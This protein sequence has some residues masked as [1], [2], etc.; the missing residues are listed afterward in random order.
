MVQ[1]HEMHGSE[2]IQKELY[3]RRS[4]REH[5]PLRAHLRGGLTVL[6]VGCGPGT[7]TA[8]IAE[9]V[10]PGQV[11]GMDLEQGSLEKASAL[12]EERE[13]TNLSF[14][15][16]SIYEI[17]FA[18]GHFDVTYARHALEWLKDPLAGLK[19]MIRVTRKG[20]V[21]TA[22]DVDYG[23]FFIYPPVPALEEWARKLQYFGA[24][25]EID[26]HGRYY[27][28]RELFGLFTL[29]GLSDLKPRAVSRMT[30]R[31]A[32]DFDW[33]LKMVVSHLGLTGPYGHLNRRMIDE[34]ILLEETLVQ[35]RA[36]FRE[37]SAA[38]GAFSTYPSWIFVAGTAA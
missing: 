24:V 33:F 6:D 1:K 4:L 28:G 37:W 12:V 2:F 31:G 30:C 26:V 34:G 9:T 25:A 16:G 17:P 5:D 21:V 3:S 10:C 15:H 23:G 38:P 14:K 13:L 11:V 8:D 36:E 19:E 35:A 20:G 29:A 22:Q 7:V 27:F 32:A 18:D